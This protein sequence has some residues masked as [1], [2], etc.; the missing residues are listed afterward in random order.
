MSGSTEDAFLLQTLV[1]AARSEHGIVSGLRAAAV[2]MPSHRSRQRLEGL[3]AAIEKGVSISA[4]TESVLPAR[5]RYLAKLVEL[6]IHTNS[7][8]HVLGE[9]V[10]VEAEAHAKRQELW[11][12]CRYPL[13]ILIVALG[14]GIATYRS[15]HNLELSAVADYSAMWGEDDSSDFRWGILDLDPV[16]YVSGIAAVGGMLLLTRLSVGKANWGAMLARVPFF[17]PLT[18]MTGLMELTHRWRLLLGYQV[19]LPASLRLVGDSLSNAYL[20][21]LCYRA[22]VGVEDGRSVASVFAESRAVP[23]LLCYILAWGEK[24]NSLP[25][26]LQLA[27]TL[28]SRQVEFRSRWLRIALPSIAFLVVAI[29]TISF[30][31]HIAR[32]VD[33]INFFRVSPTLHVRSILWQLQVLG[34]VVLGFVLVWATSLWERRLGRATG[35][36]FGLRLAG[37]ILV[38]ASLGTIVGSMTG[39]YGVPILIAVAMAIQ[40]RNRQSDRA[41]LAWVIQQAKTYQMPLPATLRAFVADRCDDFAERTRVLAAFLEKG[42]PLDRALH[43]S[44]TL[45][46]FAETLAIRLADSTGDTTSVAQSASVAESTYRTERLSSASLAGV[47]A[48]TQIVQFLAMLFLYYKVMPMFRMAFVTPPNPLAAS[49]VDY[50]LWQNLSEG[51]VFIGEHPSIAVVLIVLLIATTITG[52]LVYVGWYDY[53]PRTL[54][55]LGARYHSAMLLKLLGHFL[56]RQEPLPYVLAKLAEQY[57][58]AWVQRRLKKVAKQV[59][60]GANWVD[61]MRHAKLLSPA[62]AALLKSA[63]RN[64][65]QAWAATELADRGFRRMTARIR[66]S[67]RTL[68][69]LAV[70]LGATPLLLTSCLIMTLLTRLVLSLA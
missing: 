64:G 14:I 9:I 38:W 44:R 22:A 32:L 31:W 55:Y 66:W 46:P 58:I 4:A 11:E 45:L 20:Q 12:A 23:S 13:I 60:D 6:G 63:A 15:L 25:Q 61:A 17:G 37:W 18:I 67:T 42:V 43:Q 33:I 8:P 53:H 1:A 27:T 56:Q 30:A 52:F 50:Y 16:W 19:P 65:N 70:I 54:K 3:A 40:Q 49:K 2:D 57:P 51:G 28:L 36:V 41:Q 35:L 24:Q 39:W 48:A 7:L 69:P 26:S 62:E 59:V 34:G 68:I 5:Q 47:V 10:K 21:R 29:I